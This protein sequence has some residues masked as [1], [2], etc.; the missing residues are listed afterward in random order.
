MFFLYFYSKNI[1][2]IG[3]NALKAYETFVIQKKETSSP[4]NFKTSN[5]AKP[6]IKKPSLFHNSNSDCEVKDEVYL[7]VED[8]NKVKLHSPGKF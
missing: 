7:L 8:M 2:F 1:E 4:S 5:P 6:K 3:F